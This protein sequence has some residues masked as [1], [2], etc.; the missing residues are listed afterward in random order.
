M[1]KESICKA[2]SEGGTVLAQTGTNE[3][4]I[5]AALEYAGKGWPV[6]P[7]RRNSKVPASAH[8][9]KDATTNEIQIRRWWRDNPDANV[10][11]ATGRASGFFVVDVDVK[12]GKD[13]LGALEALCRQHGE[14]PA[15]LTAT[16][17]S[18]GRHYYFAYPE[19][20]EV[21]N[22]V[23]GLAVGLDVRGDNG[24]ITAP[25]SQID[26]KFYHWLDPDAPLAEAPVWL[27]ELANKKQRTSSRPTG[28]GGVP[29]GRRNDHVFRLACSLHGRGVPY[30]E[31]EEKVL[32]EAA[33]CEPPLDE[34][35]AL[36]ALVSAYSYPEGIRMP[37]EI[38]ELNEKYFSTTVG[39]KFVVMEE[40]LDPSF[41]HKKLESLSANSFKLKHNNCRVQTE[42]GPKPLGTCW[43]EHPKRRTYEGIV[44]EPGREVDDYYNIWR[45]FAVE[46][47]DGDCGLYLK[48]IEEN[49]TNGNP[50][51]YRYFIEWMAD[52]VQNPGKKPGTS[53]VLRGK[54]GTGK[55]IFVA[56]FGK[57][58][59][60]H[61]VHLR[62][63]KHLTGNFN[64][65]LGSALLVFADEAVWGGDK[66]AEGS[67]KGLVT[68]E[69][70]LIERKGVD[71]IPVK[72]HVHLIAASNESW[73]VPAGMEERRFCVV[74]VSNKRQQDTEY[75]GSIVKQMENGGREALL[76]YLLNYDLGGIDL[77]KIPQTGA[78]LET[79]MQS[80]S[81]VQS[82]W[83]A[84]L[85]EGVLDPNDGSWS[86]D[87]VPTDT[88]YQEYVNHVKDE[89]KAYRA[90]KAVFGAELKKLIPD[91]LKKVRRVIG[92]KRTQIYVLPSLSR[93][94]EHFENLLKQKIDWPDDES[95]N[96]EG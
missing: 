73:V 53:L 38:A 15:T 48:H 16:T 61:F 86:Q 17:P 20:V 78:L 87:G 52:L 92:E 14:L 2:L 44:F 24:S 90:S 89:G 19:S 79:K 9:H 13:G 35:E 40:R 39:G 82:F 21:C 56:E 51:V 30:E 45:G 74:D 7:L 68:E 41:G 50:E 72:N 3:K 84:K 32:D 96:W 8:G 69:T 4:A 31:A 11:I 55:G 67:L 46:P 34:A 42:S 62:H 60:E 28:D 37:P 81:P 65:H 66:Q 57:L 47:K 49:V 23:D 5:K 36:A 27:I 54:Q 94:R 64:S 25:P 70:M 71:A 43:L 77:R 6:F 18:G 12:H 10:G 1:E 59:G 58:L 91:E 63:G 29:E 85:S 95:L 93:C 80:L 22:S 83:W 76:H 88:L 33:K 26:G 75:F